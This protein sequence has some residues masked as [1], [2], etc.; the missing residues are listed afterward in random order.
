VNVATLMKIVLNTELSALLG[1]ALPLVLLK[2]ADV[3]R[4]A[5]D[6]DTSKYFNC[7]GCASYF[8]APSREFGCRNS[9]QAKS[10]RRSG[11][12]LAL[13]NGMSRSGASA[14]DDAERENLSSGCAEGHHFFPS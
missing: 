11:K 3:L 6:P 9:L 10:E 2:S 12:S 8:R 1:A 13:R 7:S 14:T 4:P 5:S